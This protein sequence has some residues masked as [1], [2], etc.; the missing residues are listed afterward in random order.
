MNLMKTGMFVA[1]QPKIGITLSQSA[2]NEFY[3]TWKASTGIRIG[4][5]TFG[6]STGS[7]ENTWKKSES[8]LTLS[9]DSTSNTPVIFGITVEQLP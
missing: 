9:A 7:T 5:F 1:Y 3:Q 4:P 2:Y 6:G 8:G